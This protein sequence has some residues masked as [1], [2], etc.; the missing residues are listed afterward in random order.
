[1]TRSI[2][3][4]IRRRVVIA[5][6]LLPAVGIARAANEDGPTATQEGSPRN[7][8][9]PS[10]PP[11]PSGGP[12][13]RLSQFMNGARGGD[14]SD[15]LVAAMRQAVAQ[16]KELRVDGRYTIHA[17]LIVPGSIT[18]VG[19][20][21]GEDGFDLVPPSTSIKGGIHAYLM[22]DHGR[23]IEGVVF[24]NLTFRGN[25]DSR[26]WQ[27]PLFVPIIRSSP[28]NG[29]VH[30]DIRIHRCRF[31][32]PSGDCIQI[33]PQPGG[34]AEKIAV[35]ECEANVTVPLD[36]STRSGDLLRTLL[37]Y[38]D[39]QGHKTSYGTVAIDGVQ[40]RNCRARGIRTLA[41]LKRGTGN[42]EVSDCRTED[43]TDCHHSADGVFHGVFQRLDGVQHSPLARA[44]DYIEVQGEDVTIRDF[45][46]DSTVAAPVGGIVITP[47]HYPVEGPTAAHPSHDIHILNGRIRGIGQ[48]AVRLIGADGVEVRNVTVADVKF[49]G[50]AVESPNGLVPGHIVID[51]LFTSDGSIATGVV[52]SKAARDVR[53]GTVTGFRARSIER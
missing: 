26:N 19:G 41:D 50:L 9:P 3:S 52:V 51:G 34:K 30:R 29:T 48:N 21:N 53:V 33:S 11:P 23:P 39:W 13:L 32:D 40:V 44:S 36:R 25:Y 22:L 43:M 14:A 12:E 2:D 1:M 38:Q 8:P 20:D 35:T 37:A 6:A 31:L 18:I 15:A 16:R 24:R 46:Y 7:P 28:Q 49:A 17:D 10:L 47:Y 4:L 27:G 5:A 42:F 45:S